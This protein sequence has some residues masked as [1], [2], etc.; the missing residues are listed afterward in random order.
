MV[1]VVEVPEITLAELVLLILV[2]VVE[3]PVRA[4][5]KRMEAQEVPAL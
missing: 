2:A 3:V 1:A 4:E 5:V